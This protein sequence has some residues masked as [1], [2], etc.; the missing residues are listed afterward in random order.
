MYDFV[1]KFAP[2]L[3]RDVVAKAVQCR[4]KAEMDELFEKV[5]LPTH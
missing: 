3:N 1:E 5:E 4:N 2:H